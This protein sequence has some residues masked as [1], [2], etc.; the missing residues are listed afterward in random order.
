[1][2]L[3]HSKALL[4]ISLL[5]PIALVGCFGN[6]LDLF[7][8]GGSGPSITDVELTPANPRMA[9]GATQ[10]FVANVTFSD[11]TMT[12][13]D[14]SKTTWSSSD[15]T[16][17]T[18]D[19]S[20]VATGVAAG[21]T[22]IEGTYHSFSGTTVLTVIAAANGAMAVRGSYRE[23]TLTF[24]ATGRSFT[25]TGNAL[26]DTISVGRVSGAGVEQ[27]V[28]SFSVE[29][30]SGPLWLAVDASGRFL[31]VTNQK[32]RDVSGYLIDAG[33]GRLSPIVG[34]PFVGPSGNGPYAVSVDSGGEFAD[35]KGLNSKET[36]R[37]RIDPL[38]GTLSLDEVPK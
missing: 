36:L 10:A 13:E 35:V 32:S 11:G 3:K 34:S 20:G 23:L 6:P 9:I 33:S 2:L 16:V 21:K 1:M 4:A 14:A 17:A 28:G 8:G 31:Y 15:T 22:T 27:P 26:D 29:P 12:K 18:I 7:G 38:T 19:K 24:P 37:Y 5:L 25:F 30:S